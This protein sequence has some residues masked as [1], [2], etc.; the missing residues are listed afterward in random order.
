MIYLHCVWCIFKTFTQLYFW[1]NICT[2]YSTTFCL[3]APNEATPRELE[4]SLQNVSCFKSIKAI[5]HFRMKFCNLL[6]HTR[7]NFVHFLNRNLRYFWWN[8]RNFWLPLT[9]T[10]LPSSRLRKA[11]KTN[12]ILSLPPFKLHFM[13]WQEYLWFA[14]EWLYSTF[15]FLR[16]SLR[17]TKASHVNRRSAVSLQYSTTVYVLV[18]LGDCCG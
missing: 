5:V 10:Q 4:R 3:Y 1:L 17:H 2:F 11:V 8:L 6:L 12:F 18:V 15:S 14:K 7:K 9:A 16:F 13:K